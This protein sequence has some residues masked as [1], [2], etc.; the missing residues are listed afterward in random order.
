ML[1]VFA[2][3]LAVL[4]IASSFDCGRKQEPE[5]VSVPPQGEEPRVTHIA[6]VKT[7]APQQ[8]VRPLVEPDVVEQL[9]KL[10]SLEAQLTALN[11]PDPTIRAAAAEK[12]VRQQGPEVVD[13]LKKALQD[14]SED[15]RWVVA[16][17]LIDFADA[18]AALE[19]MKIAVQDPSANIRLEV[20]SNLA[21]FEPP[22]ETVPLLELALKDQSETIRR[23]AVSVLGDLYVKEAIPALIEAL[24]DASPTVRDTA[25]EALTF[26]TLQPIGANYGEWKA[27][28]ARSGATF[29]LEDVHEQQQVE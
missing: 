13:A 16:T 18:T 4:F 8:T 11:S 15:V 7:V 29:R 21:F 24:Q 10:D 9:L 14:V 23:E 22:H 27:W 2:S 1:K 17:G 3:C 5:T 20:V 19:M 28:W 12:L 25:H 26:L 6:P